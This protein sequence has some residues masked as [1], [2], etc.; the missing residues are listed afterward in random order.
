VYVGVGVVTLQ[1]KIAEK[2][3]LEQ[4][5]VGV[6]VGVGHV[7]LEKYTLSKSGHGLKQGD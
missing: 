6:G 2:S 4:S 3:K 7:P 1:S 5:G